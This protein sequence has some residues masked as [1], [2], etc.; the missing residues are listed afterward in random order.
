MELLLPGVLC[1]L[2]RESHLYDFVEDSVI[3]DALVLGS[4]CRPRYFVSVARRDLGFL[5]Q[6]LVT[7]M[8]Q[9]VRLRGH[10][11]DALL[12]HVGLLE[13]VLG[14]HIVGDICKEV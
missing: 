8:S 7:A 5:H 12:G 14:R 1:I 2:F 6:S 10:F 13:D 3:A 9:H 11:L 4:L